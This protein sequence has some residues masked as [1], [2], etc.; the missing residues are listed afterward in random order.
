MAPRMRSSDAGTRP[1][2]RI[3][4][5][6]PRA[7][8]RQAQRSRAFE[9]A[10]Q[11]SRRYDL[12]STRYPRYEGVRAKFRDEVSRFQHFLSDE[13]LGQVVVNQCEV[14]Y[15]NH[16]EPC[17]AWHRFGQIEGVLRTRT[18]RG[19]S[20]LPEPEGGR[21]EQRFVIRSDSGGPSG[22]LHTSLAS[23]WTAEGQSPILVLTL[24]VRGAPIGRGIDGAFAFLDL[25]REWIVKGFAEL[26]TTDMHRVRGRID[27]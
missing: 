14:T 11:V 8:S 21:I 27:V 1:C 6:S 5:R 13:K 4:F 23:A 24:T 18:A 26:T 9:S 25:G 17:G 20:F 2:C 19:R 7:C 16:I 10:L 3:G 15:V 22:R 12:R